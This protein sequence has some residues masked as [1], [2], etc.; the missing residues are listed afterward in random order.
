[1]KKD[2]NMLAKTSTLGI[3]S[4]ESITVTFSGT[5]GNK[6]NEKV[7]KILTDKEDVQKFL[8]SE[9]RRSLGD[10]EDPMGKIDERLPV[11]S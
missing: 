2:K 7:Q 10:N 6:M 8:N 9:L 3:K 4:L 1:M 11:S 5:G